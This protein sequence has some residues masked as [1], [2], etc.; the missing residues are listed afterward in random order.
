[1]TVCKDFATKSVLDDIP[2]SRGGGKGFL[3]LNVHRKTKNSYHVPASPRA[4]NNAGNVRDACNVNNANNV[5]NMHNV[6]SVRNV[7]YVCNVRNVRNE[8]HACKM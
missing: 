1:M 5:Y 2:A 7:P 8:R 3:L 4:V 6:R